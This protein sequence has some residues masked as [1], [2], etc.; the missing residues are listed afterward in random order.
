MSF[1]GCNIPYP[2]EF[3][4]YV[5]SSDGLRNFLIGPRKRGGLRMFTVLPCFSIVFCGYEDVFYVDFAVAVYV[6]V[7][8]IAGVTI[9]AAKMQC[10]SVDVLYVNLVVCIDIAY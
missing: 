6:I 10:D 7:W 2:V 8:H 5:P 9:I 1:G 3:R 4:I